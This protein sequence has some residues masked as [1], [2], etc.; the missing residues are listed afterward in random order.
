MPVARN[1]KKLV[2]VTHLA[3]RRQE[4]LVDETRKRVRAERLL[5]VARSQLDSFKATHPE[6]KP[7]EDVV[8]LN[9]DHTDA[10]KI[11]KVS[12]Y[13]FTCYKPLVHLSTC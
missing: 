10:E 4:Q 9:V 8:L 13:W 5:G 2:R 12:V 1:K 7:P 11:F 3:K 6:W